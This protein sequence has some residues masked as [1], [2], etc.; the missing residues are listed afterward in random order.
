M[1]NTLIYLTLFLFAALLLVTNKVEAS[2]YSQ[3]I[4]GKWAVTKIIRKGK[5]IS[6]KDPMAPF[7][8]TNLEFLDNNKII[9]SAGPSK[10]QGK[11]KLNGNKL[12]FLGSKYGLDIQFPS[13]D[14][15][16][17]HYVK[18]NVKIFLKRL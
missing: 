8:K 5:E 17:V 12:T 11:W 10:M 9:V 6:D 3:K 2:N 18:D 7:K 13:N 14:K 1:K 15:L 16:I 4:L